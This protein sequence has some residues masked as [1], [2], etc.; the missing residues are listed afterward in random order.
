M[1]ELTQN[2]NALASSPARLPKAMTGGSGDCWTDVRHQIVSVLEPSAFTGR[3]KAALEQPCAGVRSGRFSEEA[4]ENL[5]EKTWT[6][7]LGWSGLRGRRGRHCA[8]GRRRH[9]WGRRLRSPAVGESGLRRH[10]LRL[11][12]GF[13]RLPVPFSLPVCMTLTA[14]AFFAASPAAIKASA[15]G[16]S[17][18]KLLA[19]SGIVTD[20]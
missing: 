8:C 5:S 10:T 15:H 3:H 19:M 12:D 16:V 2:P 7:A 1:N 20:S 17:S 13:A 14:L 6:L 9:G 18:S 4:A 11:H